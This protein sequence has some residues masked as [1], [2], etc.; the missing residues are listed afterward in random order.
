MTSQAEP[1]R[2]IPRKVLEYKS[3]LKGGS[4]FRAIERGILPE[5]V[6]IGPGT[7]RWWEHEVDEALAKLKRGKGERRG[8]VK[9]EAE[10]SA[11]E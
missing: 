4:L 1:K 10:D 2:L 3:G 6:V 7:I 8:W 11:A 5:S 9:R